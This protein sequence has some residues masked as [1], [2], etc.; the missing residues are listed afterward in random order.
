M[1]PPLNSD[2]LDEV[3]RRNLS[4]RELETLRAELRQRPAELRRLAEEQALNRALSTLR[5]PQVASNFTALVLADIDREPKTQRSWFRINLPQFRW[6]RILATASLVLVG[7]LTWSE[8]RSRERQDVAQAAAD[9]SQSA[10]VGG[11]E[12]LRD[13]EAIRALDT[14]AT[15]DDVALIAALRQTGL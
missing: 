8:R 5:T 15:P 11:V 7:T 12:T 9:I 14:T 3:E 6:G 4:E 1:E 13:F 10:H 2:W